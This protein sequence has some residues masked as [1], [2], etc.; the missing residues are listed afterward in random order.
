MKNLKKQ[1]LSEAAKIDQVN[2]LIMRESIDHLIQIKNTFNK[3]VELVK[4][5]YGDDIAEKSSACQLLNRISRQIATYKT[6]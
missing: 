3:A 4:K 6:A 2:T 5:T 1:S